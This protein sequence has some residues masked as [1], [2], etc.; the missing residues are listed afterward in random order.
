MSLLSK[1]I[2]LL[3][4]DSTV[5]DLAGNAKRLEKL[6]IS[7]TKT[8]PNWQLPPSWQFVAILLVIYCYNL[9]LLLLH[10]NPRSPLNVELPVLVGT[11][12]PSEHE[13]FTC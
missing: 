2:G 4:I 6:E 10:L 1:I 9:I 11:P 13:K 8:E 12:V 3:Q 5:G 7:L